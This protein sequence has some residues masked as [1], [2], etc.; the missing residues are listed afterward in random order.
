MALHGGMDMNI[1]GKVVLVTGASSG[2][3]AAT[4]KAMSRAG[5]RQVLL[6]AR[7]QVALGKLVDAIESAGGAARA[8]PV[9]LSELKAVEKMA[10]R[11][12]DEVGVPDILI[13]NAGS[14]RWRFLEE[15][16]AEEVVQTMAV[17]YFAA[18]WVT[19][20]FLP[21][22]MRRGSGH[23]VNISSVAARMSWPGATA[24]IAACR[25]LRG[26]PDALRADLYGT[27]V[28]VTHYESGPIDSPY[29]RNNPDSR[30]RVPGIARWLVPVLTEARVARALINGIRKNKATVVIPAMLRLVYLLHAV[31]PWLV[32]GLMTVTGYRTRSTTGNVIPETPVQ[33]DPAKGQPY[34]SPL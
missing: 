15:T 10:R 20:M 28:R 4:A 8:Y 13:N 6:L 1:T 25:A 11:I 30:Q 18:A 17:P 33:C 16:P 5:A 3:G 24:Y 12:L 21:G 26:F 9:D 31:F 23:I 32:Q 7:N 2:I 27:G 34:A 14:G 29:W 22:M 19:R